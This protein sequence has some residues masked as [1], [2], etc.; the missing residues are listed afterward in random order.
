MCK[1]YSECMCKVMEIELKWLKMAFIDRLTCC[2]SGNISL[3]CE[4]YL[5]L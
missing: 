3:K 4:G 5:H 2:N 1:V